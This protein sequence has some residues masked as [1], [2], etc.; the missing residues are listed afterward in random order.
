MNLNDVDEGPG[1]SNRAWMTGVAVALLMLAG[2]DREAPEDSAGSRGA[3]GTTEQAAPP[4][5]R[6]MGNI[7]D[8]RIMA[9][10]ESEPGSWLA[11]GQDYREQRFS[12]LT[13]VTPD[14]IGRL[15]LAWTQE[16]GDSNMRMQ[17]T[18]IVADGVMYVTNGWS[19]I[20]AL[21]AA[22][23]D[24]IWRYDPEVDRS[25]MR[26]AC[27]GPAHNR[28][29]AVYK[30]RVYV[31]T[32]DGRLVAVDAGTGELK[33]DVDTWHPSAL[34]RFNITG[35][36]RV[37]EE[38]DRPPLKDIAGQRAV[39]S[40]E[41]GLRERAR[42]S[43]APHAGGRSVGCDSKGRKSDGRLGCPGATHLRAVGEGLAERD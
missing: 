34:G 30:G 14:N 4:Q 35:A 38:D 28:G 13:Q 37:A 18:P 31:A 15:G 24:V 32:F 7:D 6:A 40:R 36:P 21:D 25:Y 3:P 27:C 5:T 2:C 1:R 22:S 8:A 26:L 12:R 39:P 33:W 29:V 16:I 42:P 23:G 9:A 10:V 19:V 11:Y 43:Q 41:G 20:Y 17:G